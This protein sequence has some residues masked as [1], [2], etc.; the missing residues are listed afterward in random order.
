MF[1]FLLSIWFFRDKYI[2]TYIDASMNMQQL[3][4]LQQTIGENGD[5]VSIIS[6]CKQAT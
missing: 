4:K 5:Q 2:F 6:L 1:L 3:Q